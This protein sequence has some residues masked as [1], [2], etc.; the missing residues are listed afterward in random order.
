[1]M[2]LKK[3]FSWLYHSRWRYLILWAVFILYLYAYFWIFCG[4]SVSPD[5][6]TAYRSID[7]RDGALA[8]LLFQYFIG[9]CVL[10]FARAAG[11]LDHRLVRDVFLFWAINSMVYYGFSLTVCTSRY[12]FRNDW[13]VCQTGSHWTIVLDI[14]TTGKIPDPPLNLDGTYNLENQ[15]YQSKLWHL[16]AGYFVRFNYN[17]IQASE[18]PIPVYA[19]SGF[20]NFTYRVE[21]AFETLKILQAAIGYWLYV[22]SAEIFKHLC[23]S[24]RAATISTALV[25]LLPFYAY[26]PFVYNNDALMIAFVLGA[27]LWALSYSRKPSFSKAALCAVFLGLGMMSKINGV[28]AAIPIAY[29]FLMRLISIGHEKKTERKEE[30]K[31]FFAQMALFAVIVFP[32]GLFHSFYAWR[33][34]GQ[35]FDYVLYP[36]DEFSNNYVNVN[37]YGVY[38]RFIGLFTSDLFVRPY[39][40][41]FGRGPWGDSYGYID[42]NIWTGLFKTAL[43]GNGV[44]QDTELENL[45]PFSLINKHVYLIFHL[46]LI[47]AFY[48]LMSWVYQLGRK[49]FPKYRHI[50]LEEGFLI[51]VGVVSLGYYVYFCVKFPFTSTMHFRYASLVIFP[52][53]ASLSRTIDEGY[54][55]WKGDSLEEREEDD[56]FRRSPLQKQDMSVFA[57]F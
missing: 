22:F 2:K 30:R 36:G 53:F 46:W 33:H 18:E 37:F 16:I 52:F 57:S 24:Q 48:G 42:F 20:P 31:A 43:F 51:V 39:K 44:F 17:F 54:L 38:N 13:W 9:V 40:Y 6:Y 45:M 55:Y 4:V 7:A 50:S 49:C 5:N 8:L 12:D 56:L 14:F 29:L 27:L 11:R 34:Y 32:L 1:M 41:D 47:I 21:L 28:L 26:I 15:F 10:A 35:S 19:Q 3:A 25:C 23:L